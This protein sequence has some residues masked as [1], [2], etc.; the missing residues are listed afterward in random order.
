MRGGGI[1]KEASFLKVL[2]LKEYREFFKTMHKYGK[3]GTE[4]A[5]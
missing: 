2:K 5:Y 3:L 1:F 4:I